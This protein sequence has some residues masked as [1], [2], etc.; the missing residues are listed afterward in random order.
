MNKERHNT[1]KFLKTNLA[2]Q[3]TNIQSKKIVIYNDNF[4]PHGEK[5]IK[6]IYYTA[7]IS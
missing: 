4:E 6:A 5:H 1:Q 3:I 2:T 7:L